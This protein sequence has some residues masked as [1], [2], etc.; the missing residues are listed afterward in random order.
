MVDNSTIFLL[1]QKK[2]ISFSFTEILDEAGRK[3]IE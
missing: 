2:F 3:C 1:F